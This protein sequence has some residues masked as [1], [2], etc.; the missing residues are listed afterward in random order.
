MTLGIF[1]IF[2]LKIQLGS[3]NW[4]FVWLLYV[5]VDLCACCM[6]VWMVR[7]CVCACV[8]FRWDSHI[9]HLMVMIGDR[10]T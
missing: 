1:R 10:Q 6:F 5:C 3:V 2:E 4:G 8:G 9:S 7:V